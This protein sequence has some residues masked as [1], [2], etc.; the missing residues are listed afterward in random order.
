M[1]LGFVHPRVQGKA[2]DSFSC[3]HLFAA[4]TSFNAQSKRTGGEQMSAENGPGGGAK[5]ATEE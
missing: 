1:D 2:G 3:C 5:T 4:T